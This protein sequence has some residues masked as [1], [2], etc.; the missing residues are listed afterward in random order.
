M[1]LSNTDH[2]WSDECFEVVGQTVARIFYV[3]YTV[4]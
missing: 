2:C 4:T 1:T 3:P